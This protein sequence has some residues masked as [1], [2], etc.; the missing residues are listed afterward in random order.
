MIFQVLLL[1]K[2][3]KCYHQFLKTKCSK[4]IVCEYLRMKC[5]GQ[6]LPLGLFVLTLIIKTNLSICLTKY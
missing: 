1:I 5:P 2:E 6:E 3:L 4:T